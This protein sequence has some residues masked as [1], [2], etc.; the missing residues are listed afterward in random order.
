MIRLHPSEPFVLG[1]CCGN[2]FCQA[3]LNDPK[4][5]GRAEEF[6]Q[7]LSREA[8]YNDWLS[9]PATTR[10]RFILSDLVADK[11]YAPR[12][13]E[14]NFSF[15]RTN[16]AYNVQWKIAYEHWRWVESAWTNEIFETA[17]PYLLDV[18]LPPLSDKLP[19]K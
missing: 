18:T 19:P 13:A 16:V 9:G 8:Q 14:G 5:E 3:I 6:G 4:L 15:M 17:V 1:T 7:C 11:E 12:A 2:C 10:C